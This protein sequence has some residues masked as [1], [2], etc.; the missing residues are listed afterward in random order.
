MIPAFTPEF[1][2]AHGE[3]VEQVCKLR[4]KNIVPE[5]VYLA[6]LQ[7]AT[8]FDAE[9]RIGEI[10]AETLILTGDADVVV[11]SQNSEN[12]ARAIPGAKL[13]IIEGGS[14]M[15]FIE[16]AE[17]FNSTVEEFIRNN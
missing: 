1:R 16:K 5:P 10:K 14:H 6:Q 9:K 4:E 7:S 15:F 13:K 12:L 17:E 3:I 2:Q 11:P 8:T